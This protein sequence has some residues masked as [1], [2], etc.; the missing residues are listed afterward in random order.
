MRAPGSIRPAKDRSTLNTFISYLKDYFRI[1]PRKSLLF[2]ILFVA[3]LVT[4][5]YSF[6]IER[7]IL[8]I[9]PWYFSLSVFFLFYGGVLAVVWGI[10]YFWGRPGQQ[11]ADQAQPYLSADNDAGRSRSAIHRG[12]GLLALAPLYFAFKMIHWDLLP[13]LPSGWSFPWDH[14]ALIVLQ[15]PAKLILLLLMLWACRKMGGWGTMKGL[16]LTTKGFSPRPYL[17]LLLFLTPLIALASTQQD[18]LRFYPK[19]KNLAFINA[20]AHP[21][22][23][24]KLLY[25]FS[26]GLDFL[27]IEL[28]F[29]GFLVIGL[30]RWAG[31]KAIL[32]M[33]AFY[34]TVHFGKPLGE[35]ISS[36]F[37]GVALGV[38][39]WRTRSILGG[40]MVHLGLAWMMELGG[41]LGNF[42]NS[43]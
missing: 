32:P 11:P 19:V 20:Y 1:V 43:H 38:I 33:A 27:S 23:P 15:L 34:C 25:E 6:G 26:Y 21:S 16:G 5:N 8:A 9:K 36:F 14:Y 30:A 2:T 12:I 42:Y 7:R 17:L 28:F 24:W 39:A 22:W 31:T 3:I 10:Q 35:C 29:R 41:W 37:G 4:F 40:L 13:L 18:F